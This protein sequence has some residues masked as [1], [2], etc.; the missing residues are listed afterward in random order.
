M[1][2]TPFAS[3]QNDR[4]MLVVKGCHRL[5]ICLIGTRIATQYS[6]LRSEALT[7]RL[8]NGLQVVGEGDNIF[9]LLAA[10]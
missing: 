4:V 5:L 1:F 10:A 7:E 2:T 3:G 9:R 6:L 8:S